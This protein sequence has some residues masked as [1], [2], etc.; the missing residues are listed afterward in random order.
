MLAKEGLLTAVGSRGFAV[1]SF[2]AAEC[3]K[4]IRLRAALEGMAARQVAERGPSPALVD[5]LRI[6]LR[7]GDAIVAGRSAAGSDDAPYSAMNG[8]FHD[9][10]VRGADDPLLLEMVERCNLVPFVAPSAVAFDRA[11]PAE[12]RQILAYAHRQHHAIV[13]ALPSRDGTR[14]EF[15]L[16]EHAVAQEQSLRLRDGWL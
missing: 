3:L 16:R 10:L 9:A 6:F 12:A 14:C 1:R 15:L 2:T 7:D 13:D 4:A 11:E 5:E 8:R